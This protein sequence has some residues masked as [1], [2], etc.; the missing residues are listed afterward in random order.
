MR[1]IFIRHA[2]STAQAGQK[3]TDASQ[4]S[5]TAKGTAQANLLAEE[6]PSAPDLILV[7]PMLRA[8]QTAEPFIERFTEVAV[9]TWPIQEFTNF[10]PDIF[11]TLP[12]EELIERV[13]RFWASDDPNYRDTP[14]AESFAMLL[15]RAEYCLR[16]LTLLPNTEAT[17]VLFTH[18]Q[19]I[20]AMRQII[21]LA[22]LNDKRKM[23]CFR[24]QDAE[25][26]V[27]NCQQVEFQRSAMTAWRAAPPT[28]TV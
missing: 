1:A 22:E 11:H 19:F 2:E 13:D 6:F 27:L 17:V 12:A 10:E 18:A 25:D 15:R 16:R 24:R 23:A 4:I 28:A 21:T 5:L 14:D 7:S 9:E 20:Q 8:M 26:P 3:I